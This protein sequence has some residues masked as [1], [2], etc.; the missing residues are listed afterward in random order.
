MWRNEALQNRGIPTIAA[1]GVA[2]ATIGNERFSNDLAII[3]TA[4]GAVL[5]RHRLPGRTLFTV[6]T[7]LDANGYVYVPTFNGRL[8]AFRPAN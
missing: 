4:T 3:D 6:G 5:D 7:T 2:Y 8:F 1:G